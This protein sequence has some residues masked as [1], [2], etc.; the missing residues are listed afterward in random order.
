LYLEL[1]FLNCKP[2][3]SGKLIL[4]KYNGETPATVKRVQTNKKQTIA[5]FPLQAFQ[6]Y[7]L[8]SEPKT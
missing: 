8:F 1:E 3:P 6:N 7:V 5:Q 2:P 4:I